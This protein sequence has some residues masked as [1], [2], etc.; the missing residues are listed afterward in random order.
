METKSDTTT[1]ASA[2]SKA[3][4]AKLLGGTI[5]V[6]QKVKGKEGERDTMKPVERKLRAEDV[7][8]FAVAGNKLVAVTAD[9]KKREAE[10]G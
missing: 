3:D 5:V 2:P 8:S 7:L 4:V 6:L 9:G 10:I 1:K